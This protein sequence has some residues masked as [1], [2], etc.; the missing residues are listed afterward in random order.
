MNLKTKPYKNYNKSKLPL[1]ISLFLLFYMISASLLTAKIIDLPETVTLFDFEENV[2]DSWSTQDINGYSDSTVRIETSQR[3]VTSGS[4]SLKLTFHKG[5]LPCVYTE[6]ITMSDWADYKTLSADVYLE[7]DSLVVFRVIQEKSSRANGWDAYMSRFERAA[8]MKKGHHSMIAL[9]K[10]KRDHQFRPTYGAVVRF[11]I[12]LYDAIEGD[13]IYVDNIRL[14]KKLPKVKDIPLSQL[15]EY[16]PTR[17]NL[18]EVLGTD[19][20]VKDFSDLAKRLKGNWRK[21]EERLAHEVE[22]SILEKYKTII[23]KHPNARLA[24]LRNGQKGYDPA[25]KDKIYKGWDDT[26]INSHEPESM[27]MYSGLV[28]YG[29]VGKFEIFMRHRAALMRVNIAHLPFNST[30]HHASLLVCRTKKLEPSRSHLNPNLWVVE[31]VNRPWVENEANA[32]QYARHKYWNNYAGRNWDGNNPDS[33]AIFAAHG[34][35]Q[36]KTNLWDMTEITQKWVNGTIANHGFWLYGD[37]HD[38]LLNAHYSESETTSKR[39]TLF[40]IYELE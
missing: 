6:S 31:L 30:I 10:H 40:V 28:N 12:A 29:N 26:Y 13:S 17:G 39:P 4:K 14:S 16:I 9:L 15:N 38:W 11:E 23:K 35:G 8:L 18:F 25:D 3:Y 21:P 34:S 7:R 36:G 37:S 24:I 5:K 2:N 19:Y 33:L 27:L 32:F 1:T 22:K 20:K